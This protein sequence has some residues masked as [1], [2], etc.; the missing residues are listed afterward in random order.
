MKKKELISK[1]DELGDKMDE[2]AGSLKSIARDAADIFVL[3]ENLPT[4]ESEIEMDDDE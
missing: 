2:L 4:E 3:I 1:L